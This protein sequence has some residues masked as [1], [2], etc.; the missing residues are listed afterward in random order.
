MTNY[1][2]KELIITK[3]VIHHNEFGLAEHFPDVSSRMVRIYTGRSSS[4]VGLCVD[5]LKDPQCIM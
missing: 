1:F 5:G 2:R 3:R 4:N